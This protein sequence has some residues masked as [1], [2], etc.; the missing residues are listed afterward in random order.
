MG[1][2]MIGTGKKHRFVDFTLCSSTFIVLAFFGGEATHSLLEIRLV[3]PSSN[4]LAS[5]PFPRFYHAI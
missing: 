5:N 2:I 4:L 1:I 3:L